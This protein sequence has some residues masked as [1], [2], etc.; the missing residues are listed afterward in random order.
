MPALIQNPWCGPT[1]RARADTWAMLVGWAS[2]PWRSVRWSSSGREIAF[3]QRDDGAFITPSR[4][5]SPR[6]PVYL[7]LARRR[8]HVR[9]AL[10]HRLPGAH[11]VLYAVLGGRVVVAM[12]FNAP[13]RSVRVFAAQRVRDSSKFAVRSA[14][15]R[16][17]RG[18]HPGSSSTRQR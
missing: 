4:S 18:L 12:A 3:R 8:G 17:T 11:R 14:D 16:A 2:F 9:S 7:A 6:A 13:C 1:R 15:C 10:P 5:G